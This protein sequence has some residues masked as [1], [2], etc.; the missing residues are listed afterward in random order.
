MR[1]ITNMITNECFNAGAG[2]FEFNL[3]FFFE[4]MPVK[5]L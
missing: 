5:G 2:N 1:V 3:R 4:T